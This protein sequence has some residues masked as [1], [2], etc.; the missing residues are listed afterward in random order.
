MIAARH[1][2]VGVIVALAVTGRAVAAQADYRLAGILATGSGESIALIELSDGRQRLFRI[3][4]AVGDGKV[5]EITAVGVRIELAEED[6][7]LRLRGN[8]Q[9]VA[10]A[11]GAPI[12]DERAQSDDEAAQSDGEAARDERH[13]VR[14]Q[15]LGASEA[16]GLLA[17]ARRASKPGPGAQPLSPES[18]R[19][20]LDSLLEV[21]EGGQIVAVNDVPV[22]TPEEVIHALAARLGETSSVRLTVSGAGALGTIVLTPDSEQ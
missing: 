21:P 22:Q 19:E 18:L 11:L 1:C 9:L 14:N 2:I 12:D 6:L 15:Q 5:R 8:P 4:D 16:A 20:Q 10:S 3:G 7:I 13:N 17:A